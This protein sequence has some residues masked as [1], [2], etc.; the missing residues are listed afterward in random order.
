[1]RIDASAMPVRPD[2][3]DRV[4]ADH[5]VPR[6]DHPIGCGGNKRDYPAEADGRRLS[7]AHRAWTRLP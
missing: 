3:G 7:R 2:K 4:P 1:M 5:R 6:G